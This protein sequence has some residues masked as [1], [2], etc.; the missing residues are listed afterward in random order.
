MSQPQPFLPESRGTHAR[1][2][3]TPDRQRRLAV[4][5]R[6]VA[7]ATMG[8][9]RLTLSD[10]D[11]HEFPWSVWDMGVPGTECVLKC[12][13]PDKKSADLIALALSSLAKL[14]QAFEDGEK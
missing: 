3:A 11:V 13:C 6:F 12:V 10:V 9:P 2:H 7:I 4:S 8:N 5:A 14:S 1:D